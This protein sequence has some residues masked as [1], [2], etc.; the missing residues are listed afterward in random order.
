[1]SKKTSS[2]LGRIKIS[3]LTSNNAIELLLIGEKKPIFSSSESSIFQKNMSISKEGNFET[4]KIYFKSL[5]K[6][7]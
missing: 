6:K 5:Q 7:K 4:V 3:L 2:L 1:M